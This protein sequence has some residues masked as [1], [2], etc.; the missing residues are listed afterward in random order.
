MR[1]TH[2]NSGKMVNDLQIQSGYLRIQPKTSVFTAASAENPF[3][4]VSRPMLGDIV[5]GRFRWAIIQI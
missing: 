5:K 3:I 1:P 4:I 2:V